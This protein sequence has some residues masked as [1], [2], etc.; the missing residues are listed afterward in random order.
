MNAASATAWSISITASVA[1][2][3]SRFRTER[4]LTSG[5]NICGRKA[6]SGSEVLLLQEVA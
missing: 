5:S 2:E 1:E 4:K 3:G 6:R